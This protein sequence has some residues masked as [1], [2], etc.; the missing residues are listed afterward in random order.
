LSGSPLAPAEPESVARLSVSRLLSG[1]VWAFAGRGV[2]T[3]LALLINAF[4]A[5]L[6]TPDQLGAYF[7]A[8]SVVTVLVLAAQLG[9]KP[10][11]VRLVA[12]SRATDRDGRARAAAGRVV[13]LGLLGSV[14]VGMLWWLLGGELAGRLFESED[15]AGVSGLI[16]IWVGVL[17][18]AELHN[19]GHRALADIRAAV[20]LGWVVNNVV[21]VLVLAV[22][23]VAGLSFGFRAALVAS[24]SER[25]N[26]ARA[27]AQPG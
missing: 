15:I 27:R 5:R 3:G 2:G 13:L 12:A 8:F 7:L 19:E 18:L 4:L 26:A 6:L 25:S 22:V 16:A 24:R 1:S 14:A 23:L 20:L 9:G 11:M 10:T 21:L 17:A